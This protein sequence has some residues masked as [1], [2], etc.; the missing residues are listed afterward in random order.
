MPASHISATQPPPSPAP[1]T[2]TSTCSPSAYSRARASA[3]FSPLWASGSTSS[4]PSGTTFRL[5]LG[6]GYDRAPRGA[7][8]IIGSSSNSYGSSPFSVALKALFDTL[9]PV[10][11]H[12]AP[13]ARQPR[14]TDVV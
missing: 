13:L 7:I 1:A 12:T 6:R 11:Y 2:S 8:K 3:P 4:A 10:L 5:P 9:C 14:P